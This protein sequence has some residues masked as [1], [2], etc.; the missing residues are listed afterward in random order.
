MYGYI[1]KTTNMINGK[2]YIGKRI[3]PEFDPNYKGSGK[4]LKLAFDKYGWE[5][6]IVE[7]LSPCFSADELNAEEQMAIYLYDSRNRSVG[8]NIARGGEGFN[9]KDLSPDKYAKWCAKISSSKSG[10]SVP[11]ERRRRIAST[12]KGS[13]LSLEHRMHI[14]QGVKGKVLSEATRLKISKSNSGELNGMYGRSGVLHPSYGQTR[15]EE[16]K[17]RMRAGNKNKKYNCTCKVCGSSFLGRS[18][19]HATC[20]TCKGVN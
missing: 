16:S 20:D 17:A 7:F 11:L 2:I 13:K 10:V 1:Y 9:G 14:S 12:L 4:I 18:P 6:F 5:N 8:Y 19:S 15:S 3:L